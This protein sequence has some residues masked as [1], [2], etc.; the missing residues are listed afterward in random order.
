M[1]KISL[2]SSLRASAKQSKIFDRITYLFVLG[3]LFVPSFMK[4]AGGDTVK[5]NNPIGGTTTLSA[6]ITQILGVVITIAT[7][8][9]ILAIIYSGFLFVKARGNPTELE[10]AKKTLM[11]TLIGVMVLL[12]AQLLSSVI[13]GTIENLK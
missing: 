12:G 2:T 5:L 7:P 9:A 8:I 10:T 4:A 6:F 3:V 13:E 11:G 1:K